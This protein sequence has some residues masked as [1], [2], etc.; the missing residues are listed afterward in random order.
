MKCRQASG[1]RFQGFKFALL[2]QI[3]TSDAK[4]RFQVSDPGFRFQVQVPDFVRC[5]DGMFC[6][7]K[8]AANISITF[9]Q[10]FLLRLQTKL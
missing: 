8:M 9:L 3:R 6:D 1:F 7:V 4:F 5:N 10:V 2:T